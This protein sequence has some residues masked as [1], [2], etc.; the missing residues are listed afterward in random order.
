MILHYS[1][2]QKIFKE[3]I[4]EVCEN[5]SKEESVSEFP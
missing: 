1:L 4:L 5:S 2:V 3:K